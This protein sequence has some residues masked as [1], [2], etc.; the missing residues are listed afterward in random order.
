MD[1][2][3]LY[4]H[5][6]FCRRR[7]SYC[8]FV[9]TAGQLK[10]LE[11]YVNAVCRE[12][13]QIHQ[14]RGSKLQVHT[15]FFGGGT[16]SLVSLAQYRTLFKAFEA[17][18]DL[19]GSAEI[20]LE[21]NPG[22]LTQG[23]LKGLHQLGFNR[24]SIG[25]QSVHADEL[26]LLH[27][28]HNAEQIRRAVDWS[29]RAGFDNLN[30]DLIFGLPYQTIEKWDQT[31]D[32]I[33]ALSPE[34]LSLYGLTI[35]DGTPLAQ[36]IEAGI[37]PMPDDDLAASMY[38]LA[39]DRLETRGYAQYEISNWAAKRNGKVQVCRH[40]LQY[41]HNQPYI[42]LGAGAHG[43]LA[44]FRTENTP[45]MEDYIRIVNDRQPQAFPRTQATTRIT[46]V[47]NWDEIQETMML[48][49]RL[50]DEGVNEQQFYERFGGQMEQIFAFEIKQLIS[51]SLLE[52]HPVAGGR[53]LRLTAR[54][55]ILG[56][57]VFVSFVGLKERQVV[58]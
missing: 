53:S 2:I 15:V 7:C 43:Y 38:E 25:A 21:A 58:I 17:A 11:D 35:E 20:S 55:R 13:E 18:F 29:R 22:T 44:G 27:R 45:D 42:G 57:R 33:T 41:W 9:T 24:I 6:P 46:P 5:I 31:L 32:W 30:L 36:S 3:S 49:L 4:C 40:N 10:R 16:P 54:G 23:Y 47:T 37:V 28:I 48:G 50:T 12:V 14:S 39:M 52:W 1:A 26:A 19:D 51:E 56:N 34:H 8:D